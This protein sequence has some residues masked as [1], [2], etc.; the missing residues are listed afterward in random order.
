M[1]IARYVMEVLLRQ[2]LLLVRHKTTS[3]PAAGN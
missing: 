2:D 1:E 3:P